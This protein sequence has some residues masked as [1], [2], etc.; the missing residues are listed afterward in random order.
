MPD[1]GK[2]SPEDVLDH[3]DG[4]TEVP[5]SVLAALTAVGERPQDLRAFRP[6]AVARTALAA[7][8][9]APPNA[10]VLS[11]VC[12]CLAEAALAQFEPADFTT[13]AW[14]LAIADHR[15]VP[16]MTAVGHQVADRAWEFSTQELSKLVFAFAEL[17]FA[18][19]AMMATVSM[20]VMW[21][22]D[23]FSSHSLAQIASSCARLGYCKEPMFDWL[24]ARV[25]GR[26][27]DYSPEDLT[28]VAWAFGQAKIKHDGLANAIAGKVAEK[29]PEVDEEDL[30]RV[31]GAFAKLRVAPRGVMQPLYHPKLCT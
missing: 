12:E 28:D 22:I 17:R 14:A 15:D 24:A 21:K 23:Q 11:A 20:E 1:A 16:A 13:F 29:L 2:Q 31:V 10:R 6:Q 5:D 27:G 18:H 3:F 4:S 9:V 25:I 7:A 19:Q 26:I 8:S 30:S